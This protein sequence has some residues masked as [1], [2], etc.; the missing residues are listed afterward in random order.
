MSQSKIASLL[1]LYST[2]VG[3]EKSSHLSLPLSFLY[4]QKGYYDSHTLLVLHSRGISRIIQA[5]FFVF[6]H[7]MQLLYEIT[8]PFL[9]VRKR[10]IKKLITYHNL[11]QSIIYPYYYCITVLY[12]T[13]NAY[14]WGILLCNKNIYRKDYDDKENMKGVGISFIRC[15]F[16]AP[17]VKWQYS[18]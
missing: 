4:T 9:E 8:L 7:S 12:C 10:D 6:E 13:L 5:I 11:C 1:L 16:S 18:V 15:S 14:C 17:G 2:V 3:K